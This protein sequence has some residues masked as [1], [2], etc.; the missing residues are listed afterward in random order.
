MIYI[1]ALLFPFLAVLFKG[2]WIAAILLLVLQVTLV[3]WLP[4]FI[5]AVL[6]INGVRSAERHAELMA[7]V[8]HGSEA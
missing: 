4:A 2:R 6:V 3:G 1:L 7:A 5:V 8:S